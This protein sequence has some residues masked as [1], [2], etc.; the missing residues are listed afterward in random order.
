MPC[1]FCVLRSAYGLDP[2]IQEEV[3][4]ETAH[5]TLNLG[6]GMEFRIGEGGEGLMARGVLPKGTQRK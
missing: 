1:T 2:L 3:D 5:T 4:R 6:N